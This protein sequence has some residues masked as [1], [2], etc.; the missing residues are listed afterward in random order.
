MKRIVIT[1]ANSYI[2]RSLIAYLQN[3]PNYVFEELDVRTD[4]WKTFDFSKFDVVFHVAAIVHQNEKQIDYSLYEKVNRDLPIALASLAKKS[5]VSQF[6]FLSSMSVYGLT[7]G[8]ITRETPLLPNTK[9]GKSK[10]EAEKQLTQLNSD[11]F[12]VAI[13]RPPMVYGPKCTGNYDKLSRLI[14]KVPFFIKVSNQRSMIYIENLCSYISILIER[15]E[16]GFFHPQNDEYVSTSSLVSKIASVHK[17][18]ILMLPLPKVFVP[19]ISKVAT[20]RKLFSDLYYDKSLE[21]EIFD[22]NIC[23]FEETVARSE[24]INDG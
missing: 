7:S 18:K 16:N 22:Y 9:Y 15:G 23:S 17:K 6:I 14:K 24:V 3:N 8:I 20:L 2:G 11:D 19:L 12:R 10:L 21:T 5:G 13:V 1:G 4:D